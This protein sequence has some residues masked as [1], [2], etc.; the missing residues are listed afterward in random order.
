MR[1]ATRTLIC[2]S[3]S[4]AVGLAAQ[5]L[6]NSTTANAQEVE[7]VRGTLF[8]DA[9]QALAAA[10]EARADLL[11]PKSFAEGMKRY[12]EA[13][14]DF[15]RGRSLED[16]NNKLRAARQYFQKATESTKL[17][18][19]TFAS[20]LAARADAHAAEAADYAA[21]E[22][23]RAEEKFSE[24]TRKLEDGDVKGAQRRSDEAEERYRQAELDAIKSN[25][26]NETWALLSEA[27]ELD[28]RDRAPR[29]LALARELVSQA[30]AQLGENRYDTDEPRSLARKARYE[31]QHAIYLSETIKAIDDDI[32]SL[33]DFILLGE[34]ELRKIASAVGVIPTFDAGFDQTAGAIV[35]AVVARED[36]LARLTG[37]LSEREQ[38]IATFEARVA[39][40]ENLV[41]DAETEKSELAQRLEAQA[42]FRRTLVAIELLFTPEEANVVRRRDD[43]ILRL[44]GLNFAVGS[45]TIEPGYFAVLTKVQ[46]AIDMYPGCTV[47]IEGHTDS[48]G[49][50]RANLQLSFERAEAVQEYLRANM[51]IEPSRIHA[52][53]HGEARPIASNETADG[54]RKN[55]RIEVIIH[56]QAAVGN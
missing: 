32:Q 23:R 11:A 44:H 55:R 34:A 56:P 12:R 48:F 5:T 49:G 28:V 19:V 25:Y 52:V 21:E 37:E 13:E 20:A 18:D 4:L 33:E 2:L 3:I 10:R 47:T 45:S 38:R 46:Q 22:W 43:V 6:S 53:G 30:E 7:H 26:L 54:R 42:E 41:G 16:I 9:D 29:T 27:E 17:A 31:A 15:E 35:S 24:A 40:L 50:D 36:S 1:T 39:E 14:E 51:Q 8:K